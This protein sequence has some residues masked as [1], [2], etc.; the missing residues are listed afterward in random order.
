MKCQNCGRELKNGA[1]FCIACGAQHDSNGQLIGGNQEKVDYNKTI[2]INNMQ[3]SGGG[4]KIDYN[5]TMMAGSTDFKPYQ[6]EQNQQNYQQQFQQQNNYSNA[7]YNQNDNNYSATPRKKKI[8]PIMIICPIIIIGALAFSFLNKGKKN[9]PKETVAPTEIVNTQAP[10]ASIPEIVEPTQPPIEGG[11]WS[12]D[13]EYFYIDGVMQT[14]MWVGDYYVGRDGKKYISRWDDEGKFYL[15]QTGKKARNEWI[16]FDYTDA[17]GKK[18]IGFY[19]VDEDGKKVMDKK[20][21]GRYINSEG[22]YWPSST[23]AIQTG[24]KGSKV[25]DNDKTENDVSEEDKK[26]TL[27]SETSASKESVKA[28]TQAMTQVTTQATTQAT[29]MPIT[30]TVVNYT[31]AQTIAP[32]EVS[33]NNVASNGTSVAYQ[34]VTESFP[35]DGITRFVNLVVNDTNYP[36]LALSVNEW[37]ANRSKK[38][39]SNEG[40]PLNNS[41]TVTYDVKVE[42]NDNK[43]FSIYETITWLDNNKAYN[44]VKNGY[45]WDVKTGEMLNIQSI[46]NGDDKFEEFSKKVITKLKSYK[47]SI[48]EDMYE[49]I[50]NE[51]PEEIYDLCSWYMGSAGITVVFNSDSIDSEKIDGISFTL[52]Y[53]ESGSNVNK[54]LLNKYR[55]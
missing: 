36:N 43:I 27:T 21:D 32:A 24:D 34:T 2:M 50:I 23:D 28:T 29:T 11:Y 20:V 48:G 17:N 12:A 52:T 16:Q 1:R 5:K 38:G 42:R 53:S 31:I 46:F 55:V 30:T 47:S 22:C 9:E 4:G 37:N 39:I 33:V 26:K 6:G 40:T 13:G 45:T 8:S 3:P 15:D 18:K 44:R 49:E 51:A 19:Y 25:E 41:L 7:G 54:L 10:I 14:N 35:N